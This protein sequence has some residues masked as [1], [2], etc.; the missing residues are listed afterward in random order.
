MTLSIVENNNEHVNCKE[1]KKINI[2]QIEKII[3]RKT[4]RMNKS[5]IEEN[6]LL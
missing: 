1:K 3:E 6:V 4:K 2:Q 5:N